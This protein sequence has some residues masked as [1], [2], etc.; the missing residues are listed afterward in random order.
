MSTQ[1]EIWR[2]LHTYGSFTYDL[3]TRTYF[4][5][6]AGALLKAA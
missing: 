1:F 3:F 5:L 2:A 6:E 4:V